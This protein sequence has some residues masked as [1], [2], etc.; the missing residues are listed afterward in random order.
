MTKQ[1]HNVSN[2]IQ[3]DAELLLTIPVYNVCLERHISPQGKL[4]LLCSFHN[5]L[6]NNI[7]NQN[8]QQRVAHYPTRHE[9][10]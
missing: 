5:P 4:D 2:S 1:Y 3:Q 9:R 8:F 6:Y 10:I 7:M